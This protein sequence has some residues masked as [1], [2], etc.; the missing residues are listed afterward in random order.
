MGD[1]VR[2]VLACRPHRA[3]QLFVGHLG[4]GDLLALPGQ[5]PVDGDL[6]VVG[7]GLQLLDGGAVELLLALGFGPR[8]AGPVA[9]RRRDRLAG[10][11]DARH[12]GPTPAL[13]V[14]Q[15]QVGPVLFVDA[16]QGRDA[17]PERV[18]GALGRSQ[19]RGRGVLGRIGGRHGEHDRQVRVA[20][21]QAREHEPAPHVDDAGLAWWERRR[22]GP[23]GAVDDLDVAVDQEPALLHVHDV[24]VGQP[25]RLTCRH[26]RRPSLDSDRSRHTTLSHQPAAEQ[27]PGHAGFR[28]ARRRRR[29]GGVRPAVGVPRPVPALRPR[30]AGGG[31]HGHAP[32]HARHR[33]AQ[34]VLGPPCGAGHARRYAPGALAGPCSARRGRRSGGVPAPSRDP[35]TRAPGPGPPGRPRL[36]G[37]ARRLLARRHGRRRDLGRRRLPPPSPC[38]TGTG[39]PGRHEPEDAGAR[40]RGG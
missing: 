4:A 28:R 31:G 19:D 20:R 29:R 35:P 8:R 11:E 14:A 13:G 33:G 32:D 18:A 3:V 17:R 25:A 40:G 2:A 6:H 5:A 27:R 16:P 12:V 26:Q 23:D 36:P 21:D 10:A 34:P 37:A 38:A 9:L 30:N 15:P 22:D 39:L 24:G 1:H 7:P